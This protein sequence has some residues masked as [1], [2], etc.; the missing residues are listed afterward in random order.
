[1]FCIPEESWWASLTSCTRGALSQRAV[2][3]GRASHACLVP[4]GEL[5]PRATGDAVTGLEYPRALNPNG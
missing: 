2:S 4:T 1:M 3:A 5:T